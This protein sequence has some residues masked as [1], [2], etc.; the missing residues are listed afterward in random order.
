MHGAR[1]GFNLVF[2]LFL[3]GSGGWR[4]EEVGGRGRTGRRGEDGGEDGGEE[5]GGGG[6]VGDVDW[7]T[8][9]EVKIARVG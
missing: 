8:P 9:S 6:R 3:N 7:P 1:A 2:L 4:G 5:G